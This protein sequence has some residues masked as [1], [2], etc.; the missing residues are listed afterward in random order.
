MSLF[1]YVI[2]KQ[3]DNRWRRIARATVRHLGEGQRLLSKERGIQLRHEL[4]IHDVAQIFTFPGTSHVFW[5][6]SPPLSELSVP[7]AF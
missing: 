7:V 5:A 2:E 4:Q 1:L 6:M 3:G